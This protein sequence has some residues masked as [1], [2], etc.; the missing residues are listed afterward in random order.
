[1]PETCLLSSI[2]LKVCYC[3]KALPNLI[4]F[5]QEPKEWKGESQSMHN[6]VFHNGVSF[7]NELSISLPHF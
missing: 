5:H 7:K 4:Y 1:M 6:T 2:T 3:P